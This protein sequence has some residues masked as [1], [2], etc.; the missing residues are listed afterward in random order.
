M[1]K[2][3]MYWRLIELILDVASSNLLGVLETTINETYLSG[4]YANIKI[5]DTGGFFIV[6]SD[7]RVISDADR[8]KLYQ[9]INSEPYFKKI[10]NIE[11]FRGVVTIDG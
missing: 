11:S 6:G 1:E 5:G 3:R 9:N 7:G 2:H 4:L 8:S 10:I